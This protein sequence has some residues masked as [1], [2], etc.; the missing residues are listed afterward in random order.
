MSMGGPQDN[1][2]GYREKV[3]GPTPCPAHPAEVREGPPEGRLRL[4]PVQPRRE[5]GGVPR[6]QVQDE[7]G[8]AT[9]ERQDHET[10]DAGSEGRADG[11]ASEGLCRA[12][13]VEGQEVLHPIPPAGDGT[14]GR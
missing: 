2:G 8:A 13:R 1:N 9:G 10:P 5:A 14:V 11:H 12:V 6:T 3:A 7:E 4:L